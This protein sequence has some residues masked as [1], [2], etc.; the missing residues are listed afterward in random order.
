MSAF[1]QVKTYRH[2][3]VVDAIV[4]VDHIDM[5]WDAGS[6]D[7]VNRESAYSLVGRGRE[8]AAEPYE[9]LVAKILAASGESPKEREKEKSPCTPLKE[10]GKKNTHT[11]RA[12]ASM[13]FTPPTQEECAA[14]AA[15]RGLTLDVQHFHDH[16]TANG[17]KISGRAPMKDW[18][19]AMRNWARRDKTM[20]PMSGYERKRAEFELQAEAAAARKEQ[21]R[22]AAVAALTAKDWSLCA[23]RCANCRGG[24]CVRGVAVPPDNKLNARPCQPEECPHFAA[25]G[26]Q[27]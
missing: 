7:G 11:P 2:D 16:Y 24:R 17:W 22:R 23:D 10:K 13:V 15:Q 6:P 19:A 4:N 12:R 1:I 9:S 3:I 14:Y 26:G 5:A 21:S 8:Q 18:R 20:R 25:K 27:A